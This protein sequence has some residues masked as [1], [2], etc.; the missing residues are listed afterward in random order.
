MYVRSGSSAATTVGN[1][2]IARFRRDSSYVHSAAGAPDRFRPY[3]T[4]RWKSG[5]AVAASQ[6][7]V[8]SWGAGARSAPRSSVKEGEV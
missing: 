7:E 1:A 2:S 8:G 5:S 6:C 3:A 4:T